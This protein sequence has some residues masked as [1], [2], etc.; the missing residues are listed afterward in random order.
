MSYTTEKELID[1]IR[2]GNETRNLLRS[3]PT[4]KEE[5]ELLD[6][7]NATN[8]SKNKISITEVGTVF[9]KDRCGFSKEEL[10]F[11]DFIK[12]ATLKI[13]KEEVSIK[14][15]EKTNKFYFI[16]PIEL[17]GE[18]IDIVA[19]EIDVKK[20]YMNNYVLGKY[21]NITSNLNE[22]HIKSLSV[23]EKKNL[24]QKQEKERN[25]I[26]NKVNTGHDML[27]PAEARIYLDYLED[28]KNTNVTTIK[29]NVKSVL[30][31]SILPSTAGIG[32]GALSTTFADSTIASSIVCGIAAA[33]AALSANDLILLHYKDVDSYG[34]PGEATVGYVK[35]KLK[36]IKE[37]LSDNKIIKA[38]ESKLRETEKNIDK[39]VIV[40]NY[41]IEENDPTTK[42][43]SLNVSDS[44]VKSLDKVVN[45]INTLNL[46][47][48]NN[49]LLEAKSILIEYIERY[50]KIINQDD[51]IIDLEAD[52][53]ETLKVETIV[54]I[55][56][57]EMKV[58]DAM[59]KEI[60]VRE[61]IDDG[62]LLVEKIND[63]VDFDA[64]LEKVHNIT[65]NKVKTK[66][67]VRNAKSIPQGKEM[68][69]LLLELAAE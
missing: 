4:Y 32:I 49:F 53:Y 48:K 20:E 14:Y 55:S 52:D 54:K 7:L 21:N 66:K 50:K 19:T 12:E 43:E 3:T 8:L 45:R 41:S 23:E 29:G 25:E 68:E 65:H 62:S 15:D 17:Y 9:M 33:F 24:L 42:N 37:K 31:S 38:K 27:S 11:K 5:N 36:E 69:E 56:L 59:E 47:D 60:R 28:L 40:N 18:L 57:L 1:S 26:I 44:I 6:R 30:N 63:F 16:K 35:D 13:S 2:R 39:M 58:N 10:I 22:L 34:F 64:E 46:E 61:V 67:L 51:T